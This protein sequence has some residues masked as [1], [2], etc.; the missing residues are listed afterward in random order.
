VPWS[1]VLK[2]GTRDRIANL[3]VTALEALREQGLAAQHAARQIHADQTLGEAERHRRAAKASSELVQAAQ[4]SVEKAIAAH[5][6]SVEELDTMLAGPTV[7]L[8]DV[9]GIEIR[10]KLAGLASDKR[11]AAIS[12]AIA[13]GDDSTVAA[14][15][16]SDRL[17]T[18]FLTDI[19]IETVRQQWALARHPDECRLLAQRK[20]NLNYLERSAAIARSWQQKTHNPAISATEVVGTVRGSLGPVPVNRSALTGIAGIAARAR[21]L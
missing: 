16:G 10:S 14:V 5:L 8:S 13:R 7:E 4:P 9:R 17:L 15:L 19:E 3:A 1:D 21:G 2:G 12:R 18:D 11:F 6:K 20:S